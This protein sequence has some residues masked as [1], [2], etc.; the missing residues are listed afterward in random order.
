[1]P[2]PLDTNIIIRHLTQDDPQQAERARAFLKRVEA[3]TDVVLLTEG[4]LVEAVQVLSSRT[5]YNRPRTEIAHRLADIVML[6]GARL[7]SKRRYLRALE[8]Y[9]TQARLDF[10]DAL[11]VAY[12]EEQQ[13]SELFS[14]DRDF[15]HVQ[16]ITRKEP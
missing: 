3:G 14:F 9:A 1:M 16:G 4:V 7:T 13:P 12:T 2:R 6:R 5:M 10:V 11:L 15:D 8:L